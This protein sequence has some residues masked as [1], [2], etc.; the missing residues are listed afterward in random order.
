MTALK[1]IISEK[2]LKSI[3]TKNEYV[4]EIVSSLTKP[5]VKKLVE[6]S[7][8]VRVIGVRMAVVG[9]KTKRVG[10]ARLAKKSGDRKRA[11][12]RLDKKDKIGLFEV[13][14]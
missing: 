6:E 2:S 12:V 7:F 5:D 4:F 13:K 9:G 10:K 11:I 3:E 1:P 8:G 14:K